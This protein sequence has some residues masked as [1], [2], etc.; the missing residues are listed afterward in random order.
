MITQAVCQFL[1]RPRAIIY[2]GQPSH[3]QSVAGWLCGIILVCLGSTAGGQNSRPD[4]PELVRESIQKQ[5]KQSNE[6]LVQMARQAG[7]EVRK[8]Y[9]NHHIFFLQDI[10]STGYP[11]Y[12]RVHNTN[13]AT[14]THTSD[15]Y[16]GGS[17]GL[18]LSGKAERLTGRLGMWD[19]GRALTTHREF[20]VGSS[21]VQNKETTGD[22]NDHTTHLAGTLIGQGLN[23]AARG[24][25]F[26]AQLSVWNFDNDIPEMATAANDLLLSNHAYGPVVGWVLNPDRPGTDIKQKW[27]WWGNSIVSPTEDYQFGFYTNKAS[28][29]DR[30]QY[31]N[32]YYLVVRSADN[33]HAET[34]PPANTAYYI[35]NT[36]EKST[37]P[38]S[39]NDGYDVIAS[40]ATA[41]N[42]LT[43]GAA[44]I[45]VGSE[46]VSRIS[47]SAYS[48]WGPTDDGRIKPDLLG[49]GLPMLSTLSSGTAAYGNLMGT[50]MASA[51]VTG[52][53]LLLQ[54]LYSRFQADKFMRAA[55]LR[56]LVLHT[57]TR[58]KPA[59]VQELVPPDYKQ[60]WGLLNLNAAAQVLLNDNGAHAMQELTLR[61]DA[62]HTFQVMAEGV[63]P[64]VV[65]I[66][67]TDPEATSTSVAPRFL[68]SRVP[69]LVNDLD[70][71]LLDGAETTAPWLLN[72][73]RPDQSATT[74]DN[75][76][77]NI[78][79]VVI[80][81]PIPGRSY[82]IRVS[83]KGELRY[84]AQP[85]SIIVSG[86]KRASCKLAVSL[87]PTPDTTLCA[88]K[89]IALTVGSVQAVASGALATDVSYSWLYN[90]DPLSGA[91]G[92]VCTA[93]QPGFYSLKVT[94]K[95]GCV[96]KSVTVEL[97][98]LPE[99]PAVTPST[100]QLLC[101]TRPSVRLSVSPE[102]GATYEW[103]RDGRTVAS[104]PMTT[105]IAT[106]PGQYG[107]RLTRQG[108]QSSSLPVTIESASEPV[109]DITPADSEI[110]IPNGSSV[111]LQINSN[112]SYQYQWL[113]N[114]QPLLNANINRWLV[115]EPGQ[116]RVRIAQQ[117]CTALSSVRTV[118]W[119]DDSKA[120][121][122]PDSILQNRPT[123][124]NLLVMPNPAFDQVQVLYFR[125]VTNT[126]HA[127][128]Y[129]T[130]GTAIS[131]PISLVMK[132]G[133]LQFTL[134]VQDL[135]HGHYFIQVIDG[136]RIRR[137]RL[138]KR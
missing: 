96:G 44:D 67:W 36:S 63:E 7:W 40:E 59:T 56:A 97:K 31:S 78:E 79:Q 109:S 75:I 134:P 8:N 26:G 115:N 138:V 38:R 124:G 9:S 83:H 2:H 135:P 11:I 20:G 41:K 111:R 118:R 94:D 65:T 113:R 45:T 74:G 104:G 33:K 105:Y 123:D 25:A 52:S 43:V 47:V 108:C 101:A 116:Y 15:L 125:P 77:D 27:E 23:P 130:S 28:D 54:E 34:G 117:G 129:N 29:I 122:L 49:V 93:N 6:R 68:N 61:Q 133:V 22:I 5:Y 112:P 39:R 107:I 17:V 132:A 92:S 89:S 13:A 30:I 114:E 58:I 71:R 103:Q 57:A 42:V 4:T 1:P 19:G 86:L 51:N 3:Y 99:S 70:L 87:V 84:G 81:K 21:R 90:G 131:N 55:T 102:S 24:M 69:K 137:A 120:T 119:A 121:A 88:G 76:R 18:A 73:N 98:G 95:S 127:I 126:P 16:A 35:R 80:Q 48:G 12:Y 136:P 72:P 53:L 60:G 110:L 37:L 10:D 14:L 50:S 91:T 66:C 128:L 100:G 85:F 106:T 82:T 46:Q 62:V 32:P 64:L